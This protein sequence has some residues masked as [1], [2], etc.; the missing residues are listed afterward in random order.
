MKAISFLI[1]TLA[2]MMTACQPAQDSADPQPFEF[3]TPSGKAKTFL[4][5]KADGFATLPDRHAVSINV[6]SIAEDQASVEHLPNLR[7]ATIQIPGNKSQK[8]VNYESGFNGTEQYLLYAQKTEQLFGKEISI[9]TLNTLKGG[10]ESNVSFYSPKRINL[11]FPGNEKILSGGSVSRKKGLTVTWD[12]DDES[13]RPLYIT[14]VV[15]SEPKNPNNKLI[16]IRKEGIEKNGKFVF[17][18]DDFKS[19]PSGS[20]IDIWGTRG[21]VGEVE[22]DKE[23][24]Q[25]VSYSNSTVFGVSFSE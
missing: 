6:N 14:L 22:I 13:K 18:T 4:S 15:D 11:K 16:T 7:V 2:V 10:R 23:L 17:S 19:V 5:I 1:V 20:T 12:P 21:N 3:F 24:V 25:V 9:Q 8:I